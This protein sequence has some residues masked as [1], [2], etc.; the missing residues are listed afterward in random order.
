M[1]FWVRT[2]SAGLKIMYSNQTMDLI[3]NDIAKLKWWHYLGDVC[4]E[5]ME[6]LNKLVSSDSCEWLNPEGK[7]II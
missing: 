2:L 4:I 6:A 5:T 3:H 7:A 1:R